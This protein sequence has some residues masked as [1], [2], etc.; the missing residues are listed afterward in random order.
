[1]YCQFFDSFG[2]EFLHWYEFLDV[3]LKDPLLRPLLLPLAAGLEW[4]FY[5]S[6]G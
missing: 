3:F 6:K 5:E 1:M 4:P 2:T